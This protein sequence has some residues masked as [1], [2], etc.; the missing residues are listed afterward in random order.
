MTIREIEEGD[1]EG[2]LRLYTELHGN[3]MPVQDEALSALWHGILEDKNHHI[4]AAEENG[5]MVSSCVAVII[6]NLT[7]G[8]RPYALI[9]NVVTAKAFRG[10]GLASACLDYARQLAIRHNC[11]KLMLLTGSKQ[12]GTLAFYRKN[13]Y[14]S[15]D[16]TGF[17]Q[18][19]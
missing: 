9:E 5:K 2:L 19:L 13:G 17:V 14:N 4:I 18:W 6:P 16:K 12:E 10:R 3:S 8:Q 7:H 15:Q 11:Y 1:L